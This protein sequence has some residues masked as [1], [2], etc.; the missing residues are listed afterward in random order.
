MGCILHDLNMTASHKNAKG[1]E[2]MNYVN[3]GNY[4]NF[5]KVGN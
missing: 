3:G 1:Y 2:G 4:S 5:N